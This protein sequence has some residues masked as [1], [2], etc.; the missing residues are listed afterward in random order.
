MPNKG[1]TTL[2]Y[3]V[4]GHLNIEDF[5]CAPIEKKEKQ[6]RKINKK[7]QKEKKKKKKQQISEFTHK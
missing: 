7:K 5:H 3:I 4:M 1:V 6:M 2:T